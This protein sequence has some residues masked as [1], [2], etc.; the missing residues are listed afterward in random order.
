MRPPTSI[1]GQVGEQERRRSQDGG[2]ALWEPGQSPE[3]VPPADSGIPRSLA[4]SGHLVLARWC[5]HSEADL[6]VTAFK[7]IPAHPPAPPGAA[8][9]HRPHPAGSHALQ[10]LPQ[11]SLSHRPTAWF[12]DIITGGRGAA[13]NQGCQEKSSK[14]SRMLSHLLSISILKRKKEPTLYEEEN[15]GSPSM[16]SQLKSLFVRINSLI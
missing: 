2:A 16:S 14:W 3:Q 15:P 4:D 8:Q 13:L 7:V 1:C 5:G 12:Y 11:A 10:E 6:E 9:A